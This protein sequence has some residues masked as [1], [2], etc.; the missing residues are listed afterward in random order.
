MAAHLHH[1]SK[2]SFYTR[3]TLCLTAQRINVVEQD[4]VEENKERSSSPDV[5]QE[6][7]RAL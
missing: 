3:F 5:V 4:V 2:N 7:T 6:K 1:P